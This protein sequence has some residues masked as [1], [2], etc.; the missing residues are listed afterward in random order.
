MGMK[1]CDDCGEQR[2]DQPKSVCPNCGNVEED[3]FE[4]WINILKLLAFS[5]IIIGI[6]DL[7]GCS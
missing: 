3:V 7:I 6:A 2:S 5:V 4:N 1:V